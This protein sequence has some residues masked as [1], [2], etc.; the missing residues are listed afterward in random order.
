MEAATVEGVSKWSHVPDA[1][2][3]TDVQK[4]GARQVGY[5]AR[6]EKMFKEINAKIVDR[7]IGCEGNRGRVTGQVNEKVGNFHKQIGKAPYRMK[8]SVLEEFRQ[9]RWDDI[10]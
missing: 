1:A 3:V 8:N 6:E 4:A 9:R 5:V 10:H 2:K 7:G